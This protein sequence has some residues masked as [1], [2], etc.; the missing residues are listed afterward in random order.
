MQV[1]YTDKQCEKNYLLT[2][3]NWTK[4]RKNLMLSLKTIMMKTVAMDTY[5]N[6]MLNILTNY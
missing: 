1:T 5:L 2:I 6:Q 4:T 3:L